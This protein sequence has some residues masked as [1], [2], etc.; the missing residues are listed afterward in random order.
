MLGGDV[1]VIRGM[2]RR[3]NS[4]I[5]AAKPASCAQGELMCCLLPGQKQHYRCAAT[6]LVA[7]ATRFLVNQATTAAKRVRLARS[8]RIDFT[9]LEVVVQTRNK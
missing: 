5:A 8:A 9:R 6:A 1:C 4:A 3:V 7:H 2:A